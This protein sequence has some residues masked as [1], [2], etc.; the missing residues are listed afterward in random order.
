MSRPA[1]AAPPAAAATAPPQLD[2]ATARRAIDAKTKPLGALGR[3]EDV[4]VQLAVLQQTLA[5]RV[6]RARVCVFAADHGIAA[7]GVSAY[8]RAVTAEMV[9]TFDRGN[10]AINVIAATGGVDVEIVDVGV[11]ADLATLSRVR[12]EK[13]R[14]GSRNAVQEPALTHAELEAALEVGR[15]A[16]RRAAAEGIDALGL[17]EMGIGNTTAAAA[18]LSALTGEP[19]MRTVGRGTGVS[20]GVLEHKRAVVERALRRHAADDPSVPALELM[21]R[22]GGLE[23]AAIAGAAAEAADRRIAV[24]AD[25]FIATVAILGAAR[26]A[27]DA[28]ARAALAAALF[29]AH[30]SA[31]Q[32]HGLAIEACRACLQCEAQPL[33]ALDMRLGEGSGA[34]LAMPLLRAAAAV[35]RDMATFAAAGVSAGAHAAAHGGTAAP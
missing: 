8:P 20:D 32:G 11:D 33:L 17:G 25:G 15:A 4:A 35:M 2:A 24:V 1:V 27:D 6:G 31:E 23:L 19:A 26:A 18:L 7:E 28:T 9:R 13:V 29:F 22:L 21:R 12:H 10:A 3:L 30:A 14:A 5:P 16:A 34:A